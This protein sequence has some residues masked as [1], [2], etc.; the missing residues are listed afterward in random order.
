MLTFQGDKYS[1]FTLRKPSPAYF[2]NDS[3][4]LVLLLLPVFSMLKCR[5]TYRFENRIAKDP[6]SKQTLI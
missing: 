5:I 1:P 4:F 2:T 6:L 3:G